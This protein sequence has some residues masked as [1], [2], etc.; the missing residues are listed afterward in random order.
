VKEDIEGRITRLRNDVK[1]TPR[2]PVPRIHLGETL[3]EAS[4]WEEASDAFRVALRL[5]P[6]PNDALNAHFGLAKASGMMDRHDEAATHFLVVVL[7]RPEYALAQSLLG[8]S[9]M[10][11][12]RLE[13]AEAALKEAARLDPGAA[14]PHRTLG[15]LWAHSRRYEEAARAFERAISLDPLYGRTVNRSR[16]HLHGDGA[17]PERGQGIS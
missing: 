12:G 17:A 3:L 9:L 8:T 7:E 14:M 11:L 16:N 1:S 15:A 10:Q 13:E 6:V 5:N 4:R 2:E